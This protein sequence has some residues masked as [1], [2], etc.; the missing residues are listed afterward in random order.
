MQLSGEYKLLNSKSKPVQFSQES[1]PKNP[2]SNPMVRLSVYL[3]FYINNV[4]IPF[5]DSLIWLPLLFLI[6]RQESKKK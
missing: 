4:L 1:K 3:S 5:L 2:Q 6:F